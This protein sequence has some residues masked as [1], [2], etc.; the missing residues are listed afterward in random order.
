[1][2]ENFAKSFRGPS[3][4]HLVFGGIRIK[5]AILHLI[6][7]MW[8]NRD[9]VKCHHKFL[10][11]VKF[12][13]IIKLALIT[14][15]MLGVWMVHNTADVNPNSEL[16]ARILFSHNSREVLQ[17]ER[18]IEADLGKQML[19]FCNGGVECVLSGDDKLLGDESYNTY[20][21]NV[22]L[23]DKIA[24]NRTVPDVRHA[25]CGMVHYDITT[26]PSAS[27]IIIFLDEPYSVLLRTIHSVLRTAPSMLLKEIIIVDDYSTFADLQ[28]K[29]SY[30]I[31][32]RFPNKVKLVRLRKQ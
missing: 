11:R 20:G 2:D 23:S 1:M 12:L 25:L 9:A 17:F 26:L 21:I 24:Y 27:V 14:L 18:E 28:G 22:V 4:C 10:R 15:M 29:L 7:T 5:C 6:F 8:L 16:L 13:S 32:T 19:G 31:K 3:Q 30:Y